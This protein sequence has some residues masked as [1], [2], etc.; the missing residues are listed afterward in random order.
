MNNHMAGV[1]KLLGLELREEFRIEKCQGL[2]RFTEDGLQRM[3]DSSTTWMLAEHFILGELLNG[4]ETVIKF[5]WKPEV[6]EQY[7]VPYVDSTAMFATWVWRDDELDLDRLRR[8]LVFST[9]DEAAALA[10][11]MLKLAEKTLAQ[12]AKKNG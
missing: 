6:G 12:E 1:A 9:P 8:K 4:K 2:F 11:K 7:Y 10:K 3:I 5:P